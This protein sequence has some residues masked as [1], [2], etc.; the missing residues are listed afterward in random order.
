MFQLIF[1]PTL[2]ETTIEEGQKAGLAPDEAATHA[3]KERSKQ[4][5]WQHA[6][7]LSRLASRPASPVASPRGPL[8][9][10]TSETSSTTTPT[11]VNSTWTVERPMYH[12][13][14]CTPCC[15]PWNTHTASATVCKRN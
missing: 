3:V 8:P 13:A 14:I 4:S 1:L 15:M 9:D 12:R 2:Q 7:S 5:F 6:H 11:Y 10:V